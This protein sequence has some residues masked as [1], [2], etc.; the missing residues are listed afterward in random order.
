MSNTDLDTL[1]SIF[2]KRLNLDKIRAILGDAQG[3]LYVN[4]RPGYMYVR[5][6]ASDGN[7]THPAMARVGGVFDVR[8]GVPVILT[9]DSD[10]ALS[11]TGADFIGQLQ[12]GYDPRMNNA[13]DKNIFGFVSQRQFATLRCQ[14]IPQQLAVSVKAWI[15]VDAEGLLHE[16]EG[17]VITL[18]SPAPNYHYLATI[19]LSTDDTLEVRYSTPKLLSDVLE[20][21]DVQECLDTRSPSAVP[22]ASWRIQGGTTQLKDEDLYYDFRQIL[23]L[24]QVRHNF[25]ASLAPTPSDDASKGYSRGSLWIDTSSQSAYICVANTTANAIWKRLDVMTTGI[26]G[27]AYGGTGADLSA[28]GGSGQFVKQLTTGGAFTVGE[29][30]SGELSNALASPPSIGSV[31][32]NSAFFTSIGL[33]VTSPSSALDVSGDIELGDSDAIVLGDPNTDG[34]WRIIRNGNDLVFQRRESAAWVT[35]QTISA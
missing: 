27:L 25:S 12:A 1:R 16:F 24:P 20:G 4:G 9:R 34:S 19:F 35:K 6:A 26:L 31:N 22:I 29:I 3:R 14:P 15:Y 32:P 30:T 33:N 13:A 18:N 5:L 28:T 23:N 11:I 2:R 8:P 21:V 17:G 10:G 7:Y